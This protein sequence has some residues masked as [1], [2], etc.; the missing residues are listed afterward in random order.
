MATTSA[1]SS[2]T[3]GADMA[4]YPRQG[5]TQHCPGLACGTIPERGPPAAPTCS[6]AQAQRHGPPLAP[7]LDRTA[8]GLSMERRLG[9]PDVGVMRSGLVL[10]VV[11]GPIGSGGPS[12]GPEKVSA[13]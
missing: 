1:G 6:I 13:G 8:P 11:G 2:Y 10:A 7:A 4:R 12:S 9:G 5:V 3:F